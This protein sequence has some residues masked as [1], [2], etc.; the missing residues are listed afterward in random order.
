MTRAQG[1]GKVNANARVAEMLYKKIATAEY[2][3]DMNT[4]YLEMRRSAT[5]ENTSATEWDYIE[6]CEIAVEENKATIALL[7]KL[8]ASI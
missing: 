8:V 1:Q 6:E 3:L 5:N 7:K 2:N 4:K